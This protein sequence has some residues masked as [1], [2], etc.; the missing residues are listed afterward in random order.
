MTMLVQQLH[1]IHSLSTYTTI[2]ST[3]VFQ[4]FQVFVLIL[5]NKIQHSNYTFNQLLSKVSAKTLKLNLNKMKTVSIGRGAHYKCFSFY[6]YHN[7]HITITKNILL[8]DLGKIR[9]FSIY[10]YLAYSILYDTIEHE[11]HIAEHGI[12]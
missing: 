6:W 1:P 7:D 5:P 4:A 8:L 3:N 12:N 10:W 11:N 2:S 9:E